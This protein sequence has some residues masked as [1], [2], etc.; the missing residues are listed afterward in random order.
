MAVKDREEQNGPTFDLKT[1]AELLRNASPEDQKAFALAAGLAP[2]TMGMTP[3]HLQVLMGTMTKVSADAQKE[4]LRSQ[5]TENPLY[6]EKSVF[7]PRGRY[8]DNGNPMSAKVT[9]RI[10]VI[11]NGV[12]LGGE[13][14]TEEEIDLCNQITESKYA[15]EGTWKA[16]LEGKGINQRLKITVPSLTVDDRMA[17]PPFT[18]ILR[19]LISGKAAVNTE[20]LHKQIADLQRRLEAVEGKPAGAAA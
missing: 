14:E 3:E 9:F 2:S 12:R 8:D 5:R 16:E 11:Y 17:L 20:S 13:L 6:P 10:P 18:M 15:R 19:E 7:N 1:L 4:A